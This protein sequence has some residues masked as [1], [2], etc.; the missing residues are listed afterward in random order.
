MMAAF[1]RPGSTALRRAPQRARPQP[2]PLWGPAA[3]WAD[4][5]PP[6]HPLADAAL[7][8][9]LR[10]REQ[11]IDAAFARI[12]PTLAAL[13]AQQFDS[14]FPVR[15]AETLR[16]QLGAAID[17]QELTATWSRPL[18]FGCLY[19]RCVLAVF[20]RL[21]EREFD[22]TLARWHEGESAPE[23]IRRFGFHA[24]DITPC[25]DGR[26]A[27][28]VDFI[29]RVPPAVVAYRK[30]YAG[31]LFDVEE[32]LRH[33]EAVELR[34]WRQG[35]PNSAAE[36]TRFLKV[37]VYHFS[38]GDPR[39]EGCAAHGSDDARAAGELLARLEAFAQAVRAVHGENAAVAT[40]LI[41]VDTDTDAV[42]VH[43]PDAVG[44]MDIGRY[45]CARD[46]YERT[47]A[48]S[49]EA[50][51]EEIRRAVAACAGVAVDDAATEGMRWFCGYLLKNN[52]GQVDAVRRRY[53][54]GYAERGHAERL[55]IVGDALDD[56][57]LRNLAFQAQMET[58][59]EGSADLAAGLRILGHTHT[60]R[61]LAVPVLVHAAYDGRM[62]GAR[63]RAGARALRL[64]RAIEARFAAEWPLA[65][66]AFVRAPG[67]AALQPVALPSPASCREKRA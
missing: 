49:R 26:L 41:G 56:V 39:H 23:L 29:L 24:L 50:A 15:A 48:L 53:G 59:E 4:A 20:Q 11:E 58:V 2:R 63:E 30:S 38:S 67:G 8:A 19:A 21:A 17:A 7:S 55:V 34:R 37:G 54:G 18:D 12:E 62:P 22:R 14:G 60:P 40:L 1:S 47:A 57:Q 5:A 33:W 9:A 51:K 10:A 31:A 52:L 43:V 42:R 46:L 61:G 16:A 25:A 32:S 28:V 3:P 35:E 27:G 6:A 66:A 64:Q 44:R 36:P 13:A 45:A 65:V